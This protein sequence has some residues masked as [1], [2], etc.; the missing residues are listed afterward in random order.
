MHHRELLNIAQT[1]SDKNHHSY[2]EDIAFT[3]LST[4][5]DLQTLSSATDSLSHRPLN[6]LL[7]F[8]MNLPAIQNNPAAQ[9]PCMLS[10]MP[11][12]F[13]GIPKQLSTGGSTMAPPSLVG[14]HIWLCV[15]WYTQAADIFCK[16]KQCARPLMTVTPQQSMETVLLDPSQDGQTTVTLAWEQAV[17]SKG[18]AAAAPASS[19]WSHS[20]DSRKNTAITKGSQQAFNW[21]KINLNEIIA[22]LLSK[23]KS[24]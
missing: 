9:L 3:C 8:A 22:G 10:A 2:L 14:W 23:F 6:V 5:W 20:A 7:V 1:T 15:Q 4:L 12:W 19:R 21:P 18:E 16:G 11:P 24:D 13:W 17:F